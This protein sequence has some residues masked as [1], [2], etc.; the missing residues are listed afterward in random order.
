MGLIGGSLGM[1]WRRSGLAGRV[2][3]LGRDEATLA[4][5]VRLGAIDTYDLDTKRALAWFDVLVLAAPV[6]AIISAAAEVGPWVAPGTVVTDVGSTKGAIVAAWDEHLAEGAAFVG[7]HPMFGRE[8]SGVEHAAADLPKGCRWVVTPGRTA[9]APAMETVTALATAAGATVVRCAPDEHDR[10][11]ALASHL[12]QV[13]ATALA[14]AVGQADPAALALAAGGFRDTTRLADSPA[15]LWTDILLT[16]PGPVLAALAAYRT[17][18]DKL[19]EAVATR[20]EEAVKSA[21]G[22]AHAARRLLGG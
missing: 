4:H 5:A 18:L 3:G 22:R 8:V 21:F 13:A 9:S 11:V 14:A 16:N 2:V 12:P 1:A 20:D 17:E 6:G 15:G 10:L 7:G 19:A